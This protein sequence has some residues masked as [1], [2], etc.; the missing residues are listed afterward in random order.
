MQWFIRYAICAIFPSGRT[1]K[2]ADQTALKPFV[3]QF[4]RETNLTMK[5]G[6]WLAALLFTILPLF[7]V[8]LP[9]PAFLLPRKLLDK[10]ADKLMTSR[11]YLLRSLVF[12]LKM[13]GGI[14]WGM[15][16]DVRKKL[17]VAPL[18]ADPGTWKGQTQ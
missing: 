10:H 17:G 18:G 12:T 15:D 16:A 4:L 14:C 11:I 6:L 7:T 2:G 5:A 9:L 13:V 3:A 1:L 8:F